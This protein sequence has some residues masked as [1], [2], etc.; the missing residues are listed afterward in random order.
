MHSAHGRAAQ[1]LYRTIEKKLYSLIYKK[2]HLDRNITLGGVAD[3]LVLLV[4]TIHNVVNLLF[5]GG[6]V[7]QCG[8]LR[9]TDT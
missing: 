8:D 7:V 3:L 2:T 1:T 6:S 9:T 5:G 4:Q